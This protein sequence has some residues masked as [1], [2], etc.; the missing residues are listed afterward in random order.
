MTSPFG[1]FACNG[2]G[3]WEAGCPELS[4]PPARDRKEHEDRIAKYV[5]WW[6]EE[7]RITAFQKQ[8]LIEAENAR[9]RKATERKTG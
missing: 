8:K 5:R 4:L 2:A 7:F 6:S 9:W 3:H 1:C